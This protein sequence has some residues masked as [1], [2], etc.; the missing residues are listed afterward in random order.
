[1]VVGQARRG[2]NLGSLEV[3]CSKAKPTGFRNLSAEGP[4]VD[5]LVIWDRTA[6]ERGLVNGLACQG[7]SARAKKVRA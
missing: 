2:S 5:I 4:E 7:S 3:S 1:M 6:L